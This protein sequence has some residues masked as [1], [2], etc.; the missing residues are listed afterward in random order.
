MFEFFNSNPL[1]ALL[2]GVVVVFVFMF[3]FVKPPKGKKGKQKKDE[4]QVVDK[5]QDDDKSEKVSD[6][7]DKS[8]T[9]SSNVKKKK[10]LHKAKQKPE[11]VQIYKRTTS[12]SLKKDDAEKEENTSFDDDLEKRAQFV[13]TT[14]KISKFIGLSDVVNEEQQ[15]EEMEFVE[16]Q[17]QAIEEDCDLCKKKIKHFDHSRRLSKM[18][19]E[20]TFDDMLDA[21]ISDKYMNINTG[22]HLKLSSDFEKKLYDRALSTLCNSDAKVIVGSDDN[23]VPAEQVK[24]DKDYMKKWLDDRKQEEYLKMI[25]KS[26]N[27]DND[28]LSEEFINDVKTDIDLSPKN[29][30]VVDAVLKRKGKRGA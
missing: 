4:K 27:S 5:K 8:E 3:I 18:V 1:L 11:I 19:K 7:T 2:I 13:K 23:N 6:K 29:V 9:D 15:L 20:E 14:N 22:R 21:H 26:G 24:N 10:H 28:E 16:P 30:V 12:S 25:I 17:I